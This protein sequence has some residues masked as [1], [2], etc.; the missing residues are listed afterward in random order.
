[1]AEKKSFANTILNFSKQFSKMSEEQKEEL[2]AAGITRESKDKLLQDEINRHDEAH[3][4]QL[5]KQYEAFLQPATKDVEE[6]EEALLECYKLFC[7]LNEVSAEYKN[8][9]LRSFDLTC[10]LCKKDDYT[11]GDRFAF[12]RLWFLNTVADSEYVPEF[13]RAENGQFYLS[14]TAREL[15]SPNSLE[16]EILRCSAESP[17]NS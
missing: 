4:E 1:M 8:A 14:F 17:D 15:W 6:D 2:S 12:L 5:R 10:P 13:V 16:K 7:Q 3:V 9:R 11:L